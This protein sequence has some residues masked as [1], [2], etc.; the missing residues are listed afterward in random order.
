M[1]QSK[2]V[3]CSPSFPPIHPLVETSKLAYSQSSLVLQMDQELRADQEVLHLPSYLMQPRPM[4]ESPGMVL[5]VVRICDWSVP[6]VQRR[7]LKWIN[8]RL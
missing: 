4:V 5:L 2:L 3:E 1:G 7:L 6:Q 8:K